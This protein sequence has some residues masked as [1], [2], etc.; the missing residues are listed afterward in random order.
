MSKCH[1][2]LLPCTQGYSSFVKTLGCIMKMYTYKSVSF[3]SLHVREKGGFLD[4]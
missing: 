1:P 2:E 4:G 3:A